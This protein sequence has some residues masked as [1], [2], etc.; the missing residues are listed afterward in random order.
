[1]VPTNL[2]VGYGMAKGKDAEA[3]GRKA[4]RQALKAI[5]EHPLSLVQIFAS[6]QYDPEALLRGVRQ[7]VGPESPLIGASTA[8]ES[9]NSVQ[10]RVVVVALAS[11]YL[12]VKVA[13]GRGVSQ[14]WEGAVIEAVTAPEIAPYFS[15]PETT[16]W[17]LLSEQGE[18]AFALLFSHGA[19]RS[20]DPDRFQVLETLERLSQGRLPILGGGA[21][22]TGRPEGNFVLAGDEVYRDGILVAVV[23]TSLTFGISRAHCFQPISRRGT[24]ALA[25]SLEGLELDGQAKAAGGEALRQALLRGSIKDPGLAMVFSS[26]PSIR[27]L[28]SRLGEEISGMMNQAPHVPMVN[29]C[30]CAPE[31]LADDAVYAHPGEVIAVLALG[32]DLTPTAQLSME[33]ESLRAALGRRDLVNAILQG[34][35]NASPI[36]IGFF[37]RWGITWP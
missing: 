10:R 11:P 23:E 30:N 15:A 4:A 37:K 36:G 3:V 20:T 9:L 33:N 21:A 12:R 28:G 1:M 25:R 31:E 29:F 13:V 14:D 26:G 2:E 35:F 34:I 32:R 27:A 5:K 7:V 19:A 16:I 17:S 22:D 18:S 8:E 24:V 6:P